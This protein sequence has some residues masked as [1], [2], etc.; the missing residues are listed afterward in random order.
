MHRGA[1]LSLRFGAQSH[2][3]ARHEGEHAFV[4]A[5]A[6]RVIAT[7]CAASLAL[8]LGVATPV[9]AQVNG[10]SDIVWVEDAL[11]KGAQT[12]SSG[13][14][15]WVWVSSNP[16]PYAGTLSH[17]SALASGT[18]KGKSLRRPLLSVAAYNV[19]GS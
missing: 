14:D 11:P 4:L 9:A 8:L 12:S 16:L 15:S 13:G 19:G 5:A 2:S 17:Q 6:T 3:R 10:A 1:L 7:A 18:R